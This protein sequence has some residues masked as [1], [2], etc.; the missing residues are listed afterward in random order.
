MLQ[1]NIEK[2]LYEWK[3][4]EKRLPLVVKGARQVG[5][6]FII[7]KFGRENYK[8]YVYINFEQHPEYKSVFEENLD[9][10]VIIMKLN[11][12]NKDFIFEPNNTLIFFDEIQKGGNCRTALKFFALDKRYDV[13]SSG[14]L[15]G[16]YHEE[17]NSFPVGYV[18]IVEMQSL[19]FDE[20]LLANGVDIKIIEYVKDK[21]EK[22]IEIDKSIHDD[23][24][25]YFKLFIVVGGMP[26]AVNKYLETKNMHD[27]YLVKKDIL[28]LYKDD[29]SKY[30][31]GTDKSKILACFDSIP[32][33]LA[34][35]N[36]KFK[37]SEVEKNGTQRKFSGA[38]EWLFDA[39]IINYCYNL[40]KIETPYEGFVVDS[41]FKVYMKDTGLLI[42]MLGEDIIEDV[43]NGKL[44]IYKGAIYE[45]IIAE[46]F[47]KNDKKLY[48]YNR[49]NSLE[50]DFIIN[51]RK[52]KTCV[53]V[54]SSENTKAKSLK[55]LINEKVV[56]CGIK[57]STYNIKI[58]NDKVINF[59]LYCSMFI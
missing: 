35:D 58:N 22:N 2:K 9:I 4:R 43:L 19:S 46:M 32:R 45:N 40:S 57:L 11:I 56:N 23:F 34:K 49:N 39:G 12:K 36:K 20:F 31:K 51:Y 5:K 33:H 38:L 13:I 1:R 21:Y 44:L 8:N 37:Y 50:I 18:E 15:L 6:T 17:V 29:V 10:D 55:T 27:V 14:S 41:E 24:M 26:Q 30:A 7:N 48:Y 59:P 16:L 25:N 28:S 42:A 52:E 54:K 53:E 47:S 3:S